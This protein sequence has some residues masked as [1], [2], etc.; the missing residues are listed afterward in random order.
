[1]G[2]VAEFS[3]CKIKDKSKRKWQELSVVSAIILPRGIL[4]KT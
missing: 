1:M 4:E 2:D 3:T